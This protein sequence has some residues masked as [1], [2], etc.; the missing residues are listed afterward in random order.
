MKKM[1]WLLTPMMLLALAAC[2]GGGGGGGATDKGTTVGSENT[3]GEDTSPKEDSVVEDEAGGNDEEITQSGTSDEESATTSVAFSEVNTQVIQA[4]CLVCHVEGGLAQATPLRYLNASQSNHLS[5]NEQTVLAY[6]TDAPENAY[7]FLQKAQGGAAHGGGAVINPSTPEY[8]LLEN[9]IGSQDGIEVT[10]TPAIQG[11]FW[12]G[13]ALASPEQTLRRAALIIARRLPTDAE[14]SAVQ[15]GGEDVLRSVVR[16]LMTGDGFK[17]FIKDGADARLL[18]R[19]M[20]TGQIDDRGLRIID[21]NNSAIDYPEGSRLWKEEFDQLGAIFIPGYHSLTEKAKEALIESPLELIAYVIENEKSYQEVLTADYLMVNPILNE[22][23]RSN[24]G[25]SIDDEISEYLPGK[26]NGRIIRNDQLKVNKLQ[27]YDDN[28]VSIEWEQVLQHSGFVTMPEAGVLSSTA[29]LQRYPTTETN[30]NR[31]RARWTYKFFLDVDIEKSASRTNDPIALADTNNPTMNNPNCTVCHQRMDPVAGAFQLYNEGG[32]RLA[33][34]NGTDSLPSIYKDSDL[35]HEGDT[36]YRDMRS[37]GFEGILATDDSLQWL[38][39]NISTDPRFGP[40]TVKFWWLGIMGSE[41]VIAPEEISDSDYNERMA[42]YTE[43]ESYINQL[44]EQFI[45]G[46]GSGQAFNAKDLFVEMVM[47]PWFRSALQ[48]SPNAMTSH[49]SEMGIRRLLTPEELE[50][51]AHSLLGVERYDLSAFKIPFGGIDGAG[52]RERAEAT[53]TL[54]AN[55]AD[56]MAFTLACPITYWEFKN[57]DEAR[58]LFGGITEQDTPESNPSAIRAKLAELHGT[59][60][61]EYVTTNSSEVALTYEFLVATYNERKASG[62]TFTG[63]GITGDNDWIPCDFEDGFDWSQWDSKDETFMIH[64]W[65][66][67]L[68]LLMS[69]YK[70]IHE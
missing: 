8:Q 60:L 38:A 42:I 58:K 47:S 28:N 33:N 52:V 11:G 12:D 55:V 27:I 2:G 1:K 66:E 15:A 65:T 19:G 64:T 20:N 18:L 30:R 9:W 48:S 46:F 62:V 7:K 56:R 22:V 23:F 51:K 63:S 37:P 25:F 13:V 57:A 29:F 43:Q 36:W 24:T 6:L 69:D 44:G 34:W 50:D 10:D 39:R 17:Q 21:Q 4:K 32:L 67:T 40:A 5:V 31:A 26:N 3:G 54:A 49:S 68:I 14:I 45:Q 61:G 70:F 35:Y 16:G 53:T 41:P 59:L